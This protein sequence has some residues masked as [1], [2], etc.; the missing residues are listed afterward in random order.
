VAN[1]KDLINREISWLSFNERVLQEASDKNNPLMERLRFLGIFSNNRDEFFRVRVATVKRLKDLKKKSL[2]EISFDPSALLSEIQEI[3]LKQQKKF[4]LVYHEIID[5]LKDENIVI[6]NENTL[7]KDHIE[8]VDEYFEE[9]VRP[10]L[11]PIIL[12]TKSKLPDL[13][14]KSLYLGVKLYNNELKDIPLYSLIEIPNNVPRFLVLP[15]L[16]DDKTY[17][18]LLDD[19]IRLSLSHIYGL[20][21]FDQIEAYAFKITRDAELDIDYDISTSLMEKMEKSLAKRKKGKQTRF[22]YDQYMPID[23]FEF[24][25]GDI[26]K[27]DTENIIPGGKYHNFKDFIGFPKI[28]KAHLYYDY[29]KPLKHPKLHKKI[30]VLNV[31]KKEDIFLSYPY[32]SFKYIVDL[33]REAAID[34]QVT[35]IQI[36]LYRV[37]KKSRIINALVNAVKNGKKVTVVIELK[38]RFDEENNIHWSNVLQENGIRVIFG[39]P[40]L[41]VHSK[42]ILITKKNATGIEHYAHI[43]TGNFHEGTAK[44]YGDYSLLTADQRIT[45]E[46]EK[47]FAFFESN[48]LRL[49]FRH[50]IVSPFSTRRKFISL[51]DNEIKNAKVKKEARITLKLNN[52]TDDTLI[53]KLYE[54]SNAGVQIDIVIRGIC[55]LVPGIKK[56]SE[57]IHAVSIVDRYLEHVRAMIFHNDGDELYFISSADWMQRNLDSRIEVTTPIYDKKIQKIIKK[58][59]SIQL[60]DNVKARLI[61]A[62]LKNEYLVNDKEP[63]Q[64]QIETYNFF[65]KYSKKQDIL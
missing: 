28:K 62:E 52:L 17:I 65:K 63:V 47:L 48:Y 8:F 38:A 55:C 58:M 25:L 31:I 39:V 4:E 7:K 26:K 64:S 11:I 10:Y 21:D 20:F 46:V 44:I 51:I 16:G 13:K 41:K 15:A 22:V 29:L 19:I 30:S 12:K 23:L 59:I 18:I 60:S 3:S 32:Q 49:S 24:L 35:Q 27:K 9:N 57:N 6:V 54:A 40:G 2:S 36:N 37:A 33:L 45:N 56:Q 5:E 53:H 14:D 1:K 34:P 50:I 43:G 42:L 61:D